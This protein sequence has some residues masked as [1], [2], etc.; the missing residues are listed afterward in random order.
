MGGCTWC[1]KHPPAP[2]EE[3]AA[4]KSA[5]KCPRL[6]VCATC[7]LKRAPCAGGVC[8]TVCTLCD[9]VGHGKKDCPTKEQ[10]KKPVICG[11]CGG[12]GHRSDSRKC[13]KRSAPATRVCSCCGDS[14]HVAGPRC[15]KARGEWIRANCPDASK[16][17]QCM[18]CDEALSK[19]CQACGELGHN[20]GTCPKP[21][22]EG[23]W[24]VPAMQAALRASGVPAAKL[25]GLAGP[26]LRT[27]TR[28]TLTR[29][30]E[31]VERGRKKHRKRAKR[32][33]EKL[34]KWTARSQRYQN[35]LSKK[36]KAEPGQEAA[37]S[38]SLSPDLE[39]AEDRVNKL[40]MS[41]RDM[42]YVPPG[43]AAS[44]S[45]VTRRLAFELKMGLD[46]DGSRLKP[47]EG[48]HKRYSKT[49]TKRRAALV[50]ATTELETARATRRELRRRDGIGASET[51]E[52]TAM[53]R[54]KIVDKVDELDDQLSEL[55]R[56]YNRFEVRDELHNECSLDSVMARTEQLPPA[57][58]L[59]A[60]D[61]DDRAS[62]DSPDDSSDE[63]CD[64]GT[65]DEWALVLDSADAAAVDTGAEEILEQLGQAKERQ[66]QCLL[67]ATDEIPMKER[68]EQRKLIDEIASVERKRKA[69]EAELGQLDTARLPTEDAADED[70]T[71]WLTDGELEA[72]VTEKR[73]P[74]AAR[75]LQNFIRHLNGG[76]AGRPEDWY[77][78]IMRPYT[79]KLN[80]SLNS[81]GHT[82]WCADHIH[83]DPNVLGIAYVPQAEPAFEERSGKRFRVVDMHQVR[84]SRRRGHCTG[85]F[86]EHRIEPK[87]LPETMQRYRN[88]FKKDQERSDAIQRELEADPRRAQASRRRI[89]AERIAQGQEKGCY[90]SGGFSLHYPGRHNEQA[91]GLRRRHRPSTTKKKTK[92]G[93]ILF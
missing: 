33:L 85:K 68:T 30:D 34:R 31:D 20:K 1:A 19:K 77:A 89:A 48:V 18:R 29:L 50:E 37:A 38:K 46:A 71:G 15:E 65:D 93:R 2:G 62:E 67:A 84:K 9:Q 44:V 22:P 90:T 26:E 81:G 25:A 74:E 56:R 78:G 11:A 72:M 3:V 66:L 39:A 64:G 8:K 24:T 42:V 87:N 43:P 86:Q 57:P 82:H 51:V 16:E 28:E 41:I 21:L 55:T 6:P 7:G 80:N 13:P 76:G 54:H 32:K 63:A 92:D 17:E 60:D 47:D 53:R 88:Q 58:P 70:V 45:E 27:M 91:T 75:K 49:Y 35:Q 73:F 5:A 10:N 14:S 61:A 83:R 59:A 52:T 69:A 4:H 36:R 23:K 40:E 79:Q 12:Q